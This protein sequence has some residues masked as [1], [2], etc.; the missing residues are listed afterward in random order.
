MT[1]QEHQR[2]PS[3]PRVIH[4][5][6]T[7][8][9]PYKEGISD[10]GHTPY[11]GLSLTGAQNLQNLAMGHYKRIMALGTK[12]DFTHIP[13]NTRLLLPN[14]GLTSRSVFKIRT[15]SNDITS[16]LEHL[17]INTGKMFAQ[18]Q[19]EKRMLH[20]ML[21]SYKLKRKK[22]KKHGLKMEWNREVLYVALFCSCSFSE[23]GMHCL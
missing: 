7:Q 11:L 10:G 9:M 6:I 22:K 14:L 16:E 23:A 19:H 2:S 1:D 12:V 21:N 17:G 15:H 4:S 8:F 18:H 3:A 13:R 20:Y 5:Y